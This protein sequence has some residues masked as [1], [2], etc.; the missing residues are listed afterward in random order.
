MGCFNLVEELPTK[1]GRLVILEF[2]DVKM[3]EDHHVL[4]NVLP[5]RP[6]ICRQHVDGN[7]FDGW[8]GMLQPLPKKL[9]RIG[10]FAITTKTTAL[11]SK[12]RTMAK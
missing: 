8:P 10:V 7:R 4:K 11:D 2:D 5:N 9:K 1:I 3:L 12:S 6:D